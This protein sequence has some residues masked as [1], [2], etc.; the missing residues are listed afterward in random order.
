M[1]GLVPLALLDEQNTERAVGAIYFVVRVLRNG[2]RGYKALSVSTEPGAEARKLAEKAIAEIEVAENA[3]I[4]DMGDNRIMDYIRE[5]EKFLSDRT[6]SDQR[7]L[8]RSGKTILE[9]MRA[10]RQ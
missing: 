1:N 5:L 6:L 9:E 8:K 10:D 3:K 7:T 4:R 2:L